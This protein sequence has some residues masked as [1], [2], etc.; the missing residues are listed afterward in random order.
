M[1]LAP[2]GA[3]CKTSFSSPPYNIPFPFI[4]SPGAKCRTSFSLASASDFV[5]LMASSMAAAPGGVNPT[6][7]KG[8]ESR[9][10][11]CWAYV[12]QHWLPLRDACFPC[13]PLDASSR[14]F[15]PAF[16][17]IALEFALFKHRCQRKDSC[18]FCLFF[19][20]FRCLGKTKQRRCSHKT[21]AGAEISKA[22]HGGPSSWRPKTGVKEKP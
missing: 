10:P 5:F 15:L 12:P 16:G 8:C 14:W 17:T 18:A 9:L 13:F 7:F 19:L 11:A 1:G 4:A 21:T 3:R 6:T 20:V 2:S 22:R